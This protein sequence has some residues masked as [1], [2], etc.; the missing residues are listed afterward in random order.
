MNQQFLNEI[1]DCVWLRDVHLGG[2]TDYKFSSFV[3]YGNEDAPTKVDLYVNTDPLITD[4]PHT[5]TF[6]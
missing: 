5:I 3:L 2:R 6:I 4:E 1:A